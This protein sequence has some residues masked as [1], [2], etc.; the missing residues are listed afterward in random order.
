MC[1]T[2]PSVKAATAG[3]AAAVGLPPAATCSAARTVDV[4]TGTG[5]AARAASAASVAARA[6]AGI[7]APRRA[8]R[9]ASSTRPR[10]SRLATVP[11]G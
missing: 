3:A 2:T 11:A 9:R 5:T 10:A 1:R 6:P 8:S 7:T 4:R